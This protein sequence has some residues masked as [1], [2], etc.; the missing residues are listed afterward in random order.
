MKRELNAILVIASRDVLKFFCDSVRILITFIFP[1]IF[2]GVLG[3]SL[4]AN[5]GQDAKFNFL[6]FTFTGVIGQVLFQSTASGIISLIEDRE[7]DF[8]QEIF[9][10]P[11]SRYSIIFGKIL[12][13]SI[14][15]FFQMIGI[16]GFGLL[17]RLPISIEGLIRILPACIIVALFGGAFGLLVLA[18]LKSQRAANQLFPFL[19]FPQFFLAG[20]FNPIKELPWY[21]LIASR[22]S[23]MT[24]AV[25]LVRSFYYLG[26]PEY[27]YVVLIGIAKNLLIIGVV[28]LVMLIVGTML[29]VR[30]ERNR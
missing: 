1:L 5:L 8:S 3:S 17:F 14:V 27:N 12:G 25:D 20:V 13:E 10:T 15:A 11:I 22:L 18:N 16:I 6:L 28:F 19:I 23:P 9:I 4:Q 2:I 7:N 26:S 30:G 29:F 24:Y 21:L